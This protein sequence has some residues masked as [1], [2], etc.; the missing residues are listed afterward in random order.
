MEKYSSESLPY[1]RA[2]AFY[3]WMDA[4][5]YTSVEKDAIKAQEAHEAKRKYENIVHYILLNKQNE[6]VQS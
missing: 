4:I 3:A 2:Q 1:Y 6:T 5:K